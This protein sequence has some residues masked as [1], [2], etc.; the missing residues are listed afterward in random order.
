MIG[1]TATHCKTH[2]FNGMI[3]LNV[4]RCM[5]TNC[6]KV[7]N[8]GFPGRKET[9]CSQ[10]KSINMINVKSKQCIHFDC[11]KQPNF[12]VPNS[13]P[14]YCSEHKLNGMIDLS[15]K[16]CTELNCGKFPSYGMSNGRP[17]HC[18]Q[19]SDCNMTD[20]VSKRC[21]L[22]QITKMNKKYKP[23][24]AQC[25]YYLN[26][27]DPKIRNYKTKEHAFTM[28]LREIYQEAILDS[29]VF[30]GCS[31]RRPDFLLDRITH[32]IIVEL[33]ENQHI[34]YDSMCE[35]KRTMELFTDLGNRP[36]VIIRLNPDGY[37]I[38]NVRQ[39]GCFGISKSTG[40][41]TKREKEFNLRFNKLV[42][43]INEKLDTVPDK[44]I[45]VVNL[46]YS[47]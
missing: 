33:D 18:K 16:R 8:Y 38:D 32:S 1:H 9:H 5:E 29:Q 30:G 40:L 13:K 22:C 17:T 23:H 31:R 27:D 19:H 21:E 39:F 24:C 28:Q 26:P 10:H 44:E 41:L 3:N 4:K 47:A 45:S 35:N 7:P 2:A 20:V 42:E 11:K 34:N 12:G 37:T 36:L 25:H 14:D 15:H 6:D 43:T 46:F